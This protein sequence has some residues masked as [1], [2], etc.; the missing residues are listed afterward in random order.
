MPGRRFDRFGICRQACPNGFH[1]LEL[2][3]DAHFI[4]RKDGDWHDRIISQRREGSIADLQEVT[5]ADEAKLRKRMEGPP[6]P[7]LRRGRRRAD[8]FRPCGDSLEDQDPLSPAL[9][10]WAIV[11]E[12]RGQRSE[13]RGQRKLSFQD[14]CVPKCNLGTRRTHHASPIA[15]HVSRI[16]HP[17]QI[18]FYFARRARRRQDGR[19]C[20][21]PWRRRR[22]SRRR[23]SGSR[24]LWPADRWQEKAGSA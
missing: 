16:T 3:F 1:G 6:T 12:P 22:G 23:R 10:R 13:V 9:K 18:A 2:F 20:S 17:R 4:E 11:K 8:F 24:F 5:G 21:G 14:N 7:R 19:W 15:Y